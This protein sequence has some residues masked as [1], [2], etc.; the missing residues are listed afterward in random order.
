MPAGFGEIRIRF[1]IDA[2]EA[3]AEELQQLITKTERYCTVLQTLRAPSPVRTLSI[4]PGHI[5][6]TSRGVEGLAR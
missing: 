1:E 4:V 2:P 6:A 3:D 5:T